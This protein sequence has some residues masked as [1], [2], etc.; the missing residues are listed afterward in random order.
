M[1]T[2]LVTVLMPVYNAEAYLHL[3]VQ[4]ILD[5][6][7]RDFHFL[8]INDG[9][10]D[11]SGEI[12]QSFEKKDDRIICINREN[13]G[14]S[15]SLNEG[16]AL[17]TTPYIARMDADDISLP[18]RL[19]QQLAFM[20]QNPKVDVLGTQAITIDENGREIDKGFLPLSDG[21]IKWSMFFKTSL[22]HPSVMIR[23]SVFDRVGLFK[24]DTRQEKIP[25]DYELWTR[26]VDELKF[27]N[28]E[29][30]LFHYRQV[31]TSLSHDGN[32]YFKEATLKISLAYM[33]RVTG[34]KLST[35]QVA[36]LIR[37]VPGEESSSDIEERLSYLIKLYRGFT[38]RYTMNAQDANWVRNNFN[39]RLSITLGALRRVSLKRFI[40]RIAALSINQPTHFLGW[41]NLQLRR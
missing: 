11:R 13:K 23:K 36:R 28:L 27:A 22:A 15:F 5:Q 6:S 34:K 24:V 1:K 35:G 29:Q 8:I 33:Q 2:P 37:E 3:A 14:L 31:S 40:F 26:G 7:L 39:Q 21:Q 19:E 10:S 32:A 16:V 17:S 25:E 38:Q 9:S 30:Y 12:I 20:E 4:S 41:F 18:R